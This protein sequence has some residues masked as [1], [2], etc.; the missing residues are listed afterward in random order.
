MWMQL[1]ENKQK[2]SL[3]KVKLAHIKLNKH[4][5]VSFPYLPASCC[6]TAQ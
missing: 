5:E 2:Y 6:C 3:T 1:K 4:L